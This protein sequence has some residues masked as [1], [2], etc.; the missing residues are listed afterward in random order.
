MQNILYYNELFF[1]QIMFLKNQTNIL[2]LIPNF[3][4]NIKFMII[5]LL[6]IN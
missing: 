6:K 3:M 5:V 1:Y 2:I 4:Y